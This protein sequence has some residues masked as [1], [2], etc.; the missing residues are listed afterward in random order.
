MNYMPEI[1]RLILTG[2]LIT[3]SHS[4]VLVFYYMLILSV[5]NISGR[6]IKADQL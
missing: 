6:Y 1:V 3:N 2:R 5:A 4:R